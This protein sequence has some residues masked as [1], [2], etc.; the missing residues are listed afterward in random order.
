MMARRRR[1]GISIHLMDVQNKTR[2]ILYGWQADT[3]NLSSAYLRSQILV[4]SEVTKP[5]CRTHLFILR[6]S[7]AHSSMNHD[8]PAPVMLTRFM[9]MNRVY[10][11]EELIYFQYHQSYMN[12]KI[13]IWYAH[14]TTLRILLLKLCKLIRLLRADSC[15]SF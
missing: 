14:C 13:S 1:N 5:C 11:D 4:C 7:D 6:G 12:E 2:G 10:K 9:I 8:V 3:S 15:L